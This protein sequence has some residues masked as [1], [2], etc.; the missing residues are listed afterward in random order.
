MLA[1]YHE[2][3]LKGLLDQ[4]HAVQ[5]EIDHHINTSCLAL[6]LTNDSCE[7]LRL[8]VEVQPQVVIEDNF[9]TRVLVQAMTSQNDYYVLTLS[10]KSTHLWQAHSDHAHAC[11]LG[12][13]PLLDKMIQAPAETPDHWNKDEA[14][15]RA[16]FVTVDQH[17]DAVLATAP[18]P[19]A[20][21]GSDRALE[22]FLNVSRH[23]E[24]ILTTTKGNFDNSTGAD[25]GK[26]AWP[27]VQ[28]AQ[29][30]KQRAS[31]QKLAAAMDGN[32]VV[33]GAEQVYTMAKQGRGETLFVEAGY[34]EPGSLKGD[35]VAVG[36][37]VGHALTDVV[38]EIVETVLEMKGQVVFVA[39]GMLADYGDKIAL[40][41]RY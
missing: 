5:A 14:V 7:Y 16:Y 9:A 18:L 17:L 6:F 13:F 15:I 24:A 27:Q 30:L 40:V 19:V 11:H 35:Q 10:E 3:D 29:L 37:H 20:V 23:A 33:F 26:V 32:K 36:V 41:Q 2:R 1:R 28:A 25:I 4:L 22:A 38:D 34:F 21:A 12:G 39:P 8:D 31:L